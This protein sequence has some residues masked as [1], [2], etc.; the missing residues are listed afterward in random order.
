[1]DRAT[2]PRALESA[3]RQTWPNLEIVVVAA[4]G[5]Q[6]R[7]LP[8]EHDGR[9][10]RLVS[11]GEKL[12]RPRAANAALEAA[13][14]EWLNFLDDDDV[15]F[16]DH[17]EVLVG[18]VQRS[19]LKGAYG[20]AWETHTA[21]TGHGGGDGYE[22]VMH[23]TRHWQRFDRL[24]L[25]HHNYLPIQAVLFHRSLLEAHGGFAEDMDQLEDWNL[26]TR[27][28]LEDDFVMVEKTTSKYRVPA[29]SRLAAGRQELL[30]KAYFDAL[31]RQ[32]AMRPNFSARQVAEMA[33]AYARSQART[34][35]THTM[36]RVVGGSR[37]LTWIASRR[38]PVVNALRR[39]GLLR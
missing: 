20:L 27:Y 5:S 4:C 2:L 3:A 31:E 34:K 12:T 19:G 17:V 18:A 26:W 35:V 10:L 21:F 38:R 37:F 7:P 30:D 36:R 39:R 1:M 23:V 22:E 29:D 13:R 6:H 8:S 9:P 33:D 15:F 32:R 24:T 16:A 11:T 28:T 14:G 25:W